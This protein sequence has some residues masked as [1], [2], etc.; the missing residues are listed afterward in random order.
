MVRGL[1]PTAAGL[2][3]SPMIVTLLLVSTLTGLRVSRSGRYVAVTVTGCLVS[4]VGLV[5]LSTLG[6]HSSLT[7][8]CGYAAVFGAGLG[9][10]VQ[11]LL[12][13]VQHS[14][15]ALSVGAATAANTYFR[16]MGAALG[17][18]GVGSAFA[19]R[20]AAT[21]VD[22]GSLTPA[23]LAELSEE[24]RALVVDA[25]ATALP[26]LFLLL[27]PLGLVSAVLLLFLR[28]VRLGD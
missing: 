15:P 6:P 24:S 20:L 13:V 8:I 16:Q 14:A 17:I 18:A 21:A 22:P 3:M 2:A 1:S 12:V 7:M 5:L 28:N 23:V 25:Y 9:S 11:L 4:T 10:I 19:A 27:A 26:P